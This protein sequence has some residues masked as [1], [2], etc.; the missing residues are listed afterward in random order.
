MKSCRDITVIQRTI[1]VFSTQRP[2]SCVSSDVGQ[3]PFFF[4]LSLTLFTERV[5]GFPFQL[6]S[7]IRFN[8]L[9]SRGDRP[10]KRT[11]SKKAH[12]ITDISLL[13][14]P[15]KRQVLV[16][17]RY[18]AHGTRRSD[19]EMKLR[20][21]PCTAS[22]STSFVYLLK[23]PF[24]SVCYSV[25]TYQLTHLLVFLINRY[26]IDKMPQVVLKYTG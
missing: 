17:P 7:S 23:R 22:F 16:N 13:C 6:S 1:S 18:F 26:C 10:T 12:I 5:Y 15:R 11:C 2:D 4:S 14:C 9:V 24:F 25:T 21:F 19:N 8:Y 20:I 3:A